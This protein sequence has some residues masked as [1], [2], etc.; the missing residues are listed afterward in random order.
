MYRIGYC[1]GCDVQIRVQDVDGRWSSKCPNY[2]E[3]DMVFADGHHIRTFICKD[4]LGNNEYEKVY[5]SI[6]ELGS[7][8]NESQRAALTFSLNTDEPKGLPIRFENQTRI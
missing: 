7:Q 4:C 3:A 5:N 8:I 1:P 6:L 2:R